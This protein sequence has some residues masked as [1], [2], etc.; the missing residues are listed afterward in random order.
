M[1][2][3]RDIEVCL[4][5]NQGKL[6]HMGLTALPARSTLAGALNLLDWRN[7]LILFDTQPDTSELTGHS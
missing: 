3:L 1:T 6:F 5:V 2:S 4:A 7:E